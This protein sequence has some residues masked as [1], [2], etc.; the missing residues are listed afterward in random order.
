MLLLMAKQRSMGFIGQVKRRAAPG[1]SGR[2]VRWLVAFFLW[3][4]MCFPFGIFFFV[5]MDLLMILDFW[6]VFF[7]FFPRCFFRFYFV[8]L[9]FGCLGIFVLPWY[10]P[11]LIQPFLG[12]KT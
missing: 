11:M 12:K 4:S 9:F 8:L 5:Y 6:D 1:T 3:G 7:F 2:A 10:E